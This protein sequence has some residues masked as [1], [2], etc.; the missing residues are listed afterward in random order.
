[1]LIHENR[2]L[3]ETL[4]RMIRSHPEFNLLA[5]VPEVGDIRSHVHDMGPGVVLLNCEGGQDALAARLEAARAELP[6]A[7]VIV[8]GVQPNRLRLAELIEVG[9]G[10]FI[11]RDAS[12]AEL[13]ATI[14]EVVAGAGV[15]PPALTATLFAEIR[16]PGT[17]DESWAQQSIP[18]TIRERQ[19]VEYV[20]R[21][22]GNDAIAVQLDIATHTVKSHMHSVLA[23]LGLQSRLQLAVRTRPFGAG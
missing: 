17:G 10:G 9:A 7:R 14:S 11:T 20:E 5:A 21:G 6:D 16:G 19:V 1:M 4:A 22:M 3:R 12:A 18:L 13:F 23:K 15:L 2:V 8:M